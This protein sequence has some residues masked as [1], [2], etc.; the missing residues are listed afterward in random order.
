MFR[1]DHDRAVAAHERHRPGAER[2]GQR[3]AQRRVA[4]EHVVGPPAAALMSK[5]GTPPPRK[6]LM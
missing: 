1:P 6:A 3:A 4:H 5:T 2:R